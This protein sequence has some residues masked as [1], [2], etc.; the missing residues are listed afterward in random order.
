MG[1]PSFAATEAVVFKGHS[2]VPHGQAN[3]PTSENR[4]VAGETRDSVDDDLRARAGVN[5]TWGR[6]NKIMDTWSTCYARR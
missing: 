1:K 6:E 3:L 5:G 4:V 2:Y